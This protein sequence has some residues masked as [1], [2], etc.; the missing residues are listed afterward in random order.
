MVLGAGMGVL[1]W[2]F[3]STKRGMDVAEEGFRRR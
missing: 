3:A 2:G 1:F